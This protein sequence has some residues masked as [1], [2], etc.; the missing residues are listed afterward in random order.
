[1]QNSTE[2]L[3]RA[4][5]TLEKYRKNKTL[6]SPAD[7]AGKY[8]IPFQKLKEQLASELSDYLKVYSLEKLSLAS[9]GYFEEFA[10]AVNQIFINT[11]MGKRIGKAAFQEFDIEQIKKL[12]EELRIRVYKEAWV[13]YFQKHICLY[14][15][16]D[17]FFGENPHIPRFYNSLVDKFFDGATGK[18]ITDETA[19]KEAI[20]ICIQEGK[21]EQK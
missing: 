15:S 2:L 14:A 7:L 3:K 13:P 4:E 18:W 20:L 16:A 11:D 5:G 1:M 9:D 17:C 21:H 8:K 12:A 6:V 19:P 10:S